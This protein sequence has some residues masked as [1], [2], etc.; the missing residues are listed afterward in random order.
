MPE[1]AP[2]QAQRFSQG[3]RSN[4]PR[5]RLVRWAML[6]I[7]VALLVTLV[8]FANRAL[9][10]GSAISPQA[11]LSTQTGYVSGVDRVNVVVL[12]YGG[13]GHDGAYLSD[14]LMV[15][16]LVPGDHATTMVSVPRDIWVQIPPN[17][18]QYGKLNTAFQDG[19]TN[20]YGNYPAGQMAGGLEAAAKV[21]D[22][23]GLNVPYFMSINFQG[24]RALVDSL[25]GVDVNVATAFTARY[26][27][28]DDPQINAG[29]KVIHFNAGPQHMNGEQA[30]EY[31]R[32]RY[33]LSP[34]SEG[35]DFA[36]SARQQLLIH[37]I[38]DRLRSPTAWPGF[39]N[40]MDAL[41]KAIYTN[42]SLADLSAY[43]LKLDLSHAKRIGLSNA[44]V[45][46][47]STSSDGQSIL[48]PQNGDWGAVKQY[49][50]SGLAP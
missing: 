18:G 16:S 23:T 36:R 31:A 22:V 14:S 33:V 42:L 43:V 25:G 35:S 7:V 19:M 20:G 9:A 45:L 4:A 24:F 11:P 3:G 2:R 8:A 12:G 6:A 38:A 21:S 46:T 5:R 30:I 40:A 15:M 50:S 17:S 34:A 41:Q 44:N 48:L 27:I 39:S 37:A 28:N 13:A 29:W 47:D 32:A 26:P 10:F 49:V 1:Q